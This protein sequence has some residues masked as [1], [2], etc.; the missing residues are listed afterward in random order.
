M[1]GAELDLLTK[2]ISDMENNRGTERFTKAYKNFVQ[3]AANH[4]T[5]VTPFLPT[6]TSLL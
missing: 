3:A 1:K 4:M 5:I 6:L 2:S